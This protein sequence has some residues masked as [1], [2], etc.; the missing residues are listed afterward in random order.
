MRATN[1]A[2]NIHEE[3]SSINICFHV[4]GCT[5]TRA[6]LCTMSRAFAVSGTGCLA[7][8]SVR[9]VSARA[10]RRT[11]LSVRASLVTVTFTPFGGGDS[12]VSEVTKAS[13][14]REVALGDTVPLYSGMSKLM[15]C[16]GNGNC[17]TCRVIITEGAEL[18]SERTDAERRKLKGKGEDNRLACQCLVGGPDAPELAQLKVT[19]TPPK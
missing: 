7:S 12:I 18:L 10:S 11:A 1:N 9:R 16:G 19:V 4:A 2:K 14:L 13:V 8:V 17:G 3:S 5:P 15:N 6:P